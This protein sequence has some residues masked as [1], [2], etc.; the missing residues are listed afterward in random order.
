MMASWFCNLRHSFQIQDS[1]SWRRNRDR[2]GFLRKQRSGTLSQGA[3]YY[4]VGQEPKPQESRM[5]ASSLTVE[6]CCRPLHRS[7]FTESTSPQHPVISRVWKRSTKQ[8]HTRLRSSSIHPPV[9]SLLLPALAES[10]E[11]NVYA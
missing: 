8:H 6:N 9:L 7:P 3:T 11:L 1:V 2:S 10:R 5:G 4:V